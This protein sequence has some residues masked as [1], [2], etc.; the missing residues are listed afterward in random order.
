MVCKTDRLWLYHI[1]RY[2]QHTGSGC[3]IINGMKIRHDMAIPNIPVKDRY[4]DSGEYVYTADN[5]IVDRNGKI[6]QTGYGDV[7]INGM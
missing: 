2:V 3:V 1:K 4:Q 5:G 7:I 6:E